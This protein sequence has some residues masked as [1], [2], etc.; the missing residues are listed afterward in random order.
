MPVNDKRDRNSWYNTIPVENVRRRT[1]FSDP[2]FNV[3]QMKENEIKAGPEIIVAKIPQIKGRIYRRKDKERNQTYIVLIADRYPDPANRKNTISD[4]VNI[5]T[6]LFGQFAGLMVISDNYHDYFNKQGDLVNDP[7]KRRKEREERERAEQEA[8]A[9]TKEAETTE[10]ATTEETAEATWGETDEATWEE[11][12][13]A[14]T[15]PLSTGA[16]PGAHLPAQWPRDE[17]RTVDEIKASLLEQEKRLAEKEE[18]LN[19]DLRKAK[20]SCRTFMT[21]RKSWIK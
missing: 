5:G 14:T 10:E 1:F 8:S 16:Q 11:T 9:K 18:R 15:G 21:G 19:E 17:E 4:R 12:D 13:E 3:D 6:E 2:N 20:K 7:M